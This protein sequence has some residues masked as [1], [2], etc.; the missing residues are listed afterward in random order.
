MYAELAI[1]GSIFN[2]FGGCATNEAIHL[3]FFH[4]LSQASFSTH[5]HRARTCSVF[6]PQVRRC[7][8]ES[9]FGTMKPKMTG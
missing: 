1:R 3:A 4:K 8:K 5:L 7:Q 6:A 2:G 9:H